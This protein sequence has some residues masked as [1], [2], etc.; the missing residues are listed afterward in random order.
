MRRLA[1]PV[2]LSHTAA[3]LKLVAKDAAWDAAGGGPSYSS[4]VTGSRK[5]HNITAI[6]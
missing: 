3:R 2:R 6:P 4:G 5:R 1:C